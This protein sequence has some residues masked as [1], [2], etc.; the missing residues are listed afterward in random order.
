MNL[1]IVKNQHN[2]KSYYSDFVF[3]MQSF[4]IVENSEQLDGIL[5]IN[6]QIKI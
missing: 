5:L 4:K 1:K 3:S 6:L 2:L